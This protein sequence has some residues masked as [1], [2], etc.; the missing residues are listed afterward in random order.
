MASRVA[1]AFW[2][3]ILLAG[4]ARAEPPP[5]IAPGV[6]T[7]VTLQPVAVYDADG[8]QVFGP[9]GGIATVPFQ[10]LGKAFALPVS[11]TP[12][13]YA[14]VQPA[15]A[16]A[17][18]GINPCSVDIVIST[19]TASMPAA[20]QP[21]TMGGKTIPNVQIVTSPTGVVNEFEDTYFMARSGRILSSSANPMSGSIRYVS[22]MALADPGATHCAFRLGYGGGGS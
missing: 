6:P 13:T 4:P 5:A 15:G 9:G 14:I 2:G 3:L 22:I 8:N 12:Q 7:S 18:R 19:V 11:T 1:L 21:V 16:K 10:R 20:T 17:Y